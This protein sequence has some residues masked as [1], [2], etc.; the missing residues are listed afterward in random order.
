MSE[1]ISQTEKASALPAE[2]TANIG[3]LAT[4][5]FNPVSE[6]LGTVEELTLG[7]GGSN[8]DDDTHSSRHTQPTVT[9]TFKGLTPLE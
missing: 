5:H 9:P 2:V 8:A 3:G 6:I 7:G 1:F 4:K